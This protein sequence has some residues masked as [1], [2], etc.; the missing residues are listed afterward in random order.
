MSGSIS[1]TVT[2]YDITD[3]SNALGLETDLYGPF[4]R[5]NAEQPVRAGRQFQIKVNNW[6]GQA[7]L[8]I[9]FSDQSSGYLTSWFWNFGDGSSGYG[10]NPSPAYSAPGIYTVSMM[11]SGPDG[12]VYINHDL[13]HNGLH[14][15]LKFMPLQGTFHNLKLTAQI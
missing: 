12:S 7:P 5:P 4:K 9:N 15:D 11:V 10:Q 3:S 1:A 2:G 14:P 8:Q 6:F 13:H